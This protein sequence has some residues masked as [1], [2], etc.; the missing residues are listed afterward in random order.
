MLLRVQKI[1]QLY[2]WKLLIVSHLL[3]KF[4]GHRPCGS[5]GI[6]DLIFH[7]TLQDHVIKRPC[8]FRKGSSSLDILTLSSSVVAVV[9]I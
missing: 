6:I 9:N 8:D 7:V 3:T 4:G 5:R 1:L 2:S